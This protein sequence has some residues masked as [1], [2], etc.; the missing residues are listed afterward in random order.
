MGGG[1]SR[2][3][4]A[5]K[6]QVAEAKTYFGTTNGKDIAKT[7]GAPHRISLI[8]EE[9]TPICYAYLQVSEKY[10]TDSK[11]GPIAYEC[12]AD[13]L[14][15]QLKGRRYESLV[16]LQK[17]IF[18]E[19]SKGIFS[20]PPSI[21]AEGLHRDHHLGHTRAD[22]PEIKKHVWVQRPNPLLVEEFLTAVLPDRVE[23]YEM[24]SKSSA[25]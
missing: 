20:Q 14:S 23:A 5:L 2:Y 21:L 18:Y 16:A 19:W 3:R 24:Y 15:A 22:F 4:E 1:Y 9:N 10:M 25:K 8:S 17:G 7:K 11:E 13:E 6:K 12:S